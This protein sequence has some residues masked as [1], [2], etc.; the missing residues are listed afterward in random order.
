MKKMMTAMAAFT[1]VLGTAACNGGADTEE[2]ASSGTIAGT[3]K[4]DP[5]SAEAENDTRSFV[6]A[7]GE[8]T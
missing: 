5:S 8:Y 4:A 2:A 6:L 3:W 1:L 7:D